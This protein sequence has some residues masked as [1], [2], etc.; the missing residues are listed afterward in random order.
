M[1]RN[2]GIIRLEIFLFL[3]LLILVF[4][5][6]AQAGKQ[7]SKDTSTGTEGITMNF[8]GN[9]PQDKYIVTDE[10][11]E[12]I[13]II[14]ELRNKGSYP[15]ENDVNELSRGQVYISGFDDNIIH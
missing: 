12:S 10:Q 1:A 6:Q 9:N 4:G 13:S 11:E 8:L 15:R 7:S 3:L 2:T 5:C 14:L